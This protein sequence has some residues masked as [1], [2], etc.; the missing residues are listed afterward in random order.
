MSAYQRGYHAQTTEQIHIQSSTETKAA[1]P[2]R[3][4]YRAYCQEDD[5]A[6]A[7]IREKYGI[8]SDEDAI[9]LALRLVAGDAIQVKTVAPAAR[10]SATQVKAKR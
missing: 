10:R 9:R 6:V 5:D 3:R 1:Y 4:Y 8:H 2:A 7:A